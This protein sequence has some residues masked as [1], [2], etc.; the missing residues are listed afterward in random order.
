MA[1]VIDTVASL[2]KVQERIKNYLYIFEV[3]K[4]FS[5]A[6]LAAR[7]L[8]QYRIFFNAKCDTTFH[9]GGKL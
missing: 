5:Q 6:L 7:F 8:H 9:A 1:R 4:Y 3:E 2:L